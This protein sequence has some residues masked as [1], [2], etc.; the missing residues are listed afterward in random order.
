MTSDPI[1]EGL[2]KYQALLLEHQ[3]DIPR[4]GLG[5]FLDKVEREG[6]GMFREAHQFQIR[7]QYL[8]NSNYPPNVYMGRPVEPYYTT[9]FDLTNQQILE[10]LKLNYIAV[11]HGNCS[12]LSL[13]HRIEV[14]KIEDE[15]N[16]E[17]TSSN[18]SISLFGK[19]VGKTMEIGGGFLGYLGIPVVLGGVYLDNSSTYE[20]EEM[21][22]ERLKTI[23]SEEQLKDPKIRDVLVDLQLADKAMNHLVA[24]AATDSD[25]KKWLEGQLAQFKE[26]YN[27]QLNQITQEMGQRIAFIYQKIKKA[28][29]QKIKE[30]NACQQL[31]RFEQIES[32]FA[33]LGR[34]GATVNN[35][36]LAKIGQAGSLAVNIFKNISILTGSF[37]LQKAVDLAALNPALGL[38]LS[39]F[40]LG[41]L[42]FGRRRRGPNMAKVIS[43]ILNQYISQLYKQMG[44]S[45][46]EMWKNQKRLYEFMKYDVLFLTLEGQEGIRSRGSSLLAV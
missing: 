24:V 26:R 34:I 46:A 38:T 4:N 31:H 33:T 23:F 44:A 3:H 25:T 2:Q 40:S 36:A 45:F 22:L 13:N 42:L 19:I 17:R 7:N 15:Y 12:Q 10:R 28:E 30:L 9:S 11:T 14:V 41:S 20:T 43:K 29:E 32:A 8:Q 37:G 39:L 16:R 6:L 5:T 21:G 1:A 27:V 18:A 35:A